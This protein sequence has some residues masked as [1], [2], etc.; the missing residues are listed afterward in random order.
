MTPT[1]INEPFECTVTWAEGAHTNSR[2]ALH[3]FTGDFSYDEHGWCNFSFHLNLLFFLSSLEYLKS[4]QG[5]AAAW[6]ELASDFWSDNR[7][8]EH[9]KSS[10]T[11]GSLNATP[12]SEMSPCH[13]RKVERVSSHPLNFL[14]G[15]YQRAEDNTSSVSQCDDR[16]SNESFKEGSTRCNR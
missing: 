6:T 13:V 9:I 11:S 5:Q 15:G 12:G 7:R 3:L 4:S 2:I 1:I 10:E 14:R 8:K 16:C